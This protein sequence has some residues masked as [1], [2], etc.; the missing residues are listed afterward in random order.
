MAE[1]IGRRATLAVSA[2]LAYLAELVVLAVWQWPPPEGLL[3]VA[4][5]LTVVLLPPLALA[6]TRR[7]FP[8][9]VACY[10]VATVLGALAGGIFLVPSVALLALAA[11]APPSPRR[12]WSRLPR[13]LVVASVAVPL[14]LVAAALLTPSSPEGLTVC[15]AA[16]EPPPFDRRGWS[17]TSAVPGGFRL[18]FGNGMTERRRDA[19]AAELRRQPGVTRVSVGYASCP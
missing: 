18:D 14:A 12:W 10:A 7:A 15:T 5:L 17:A 2:V 6:G 11:F 16:P 13:P 19:V 9:V 8:V 4:A 1:G 3:A